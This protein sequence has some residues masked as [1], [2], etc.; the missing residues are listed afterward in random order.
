M[1]TK[2]NDDEQYIWESAAGGTFTIT[3]DTVNPSLGRGTQL[4][5][6]MKEDQLDYLEEKKIKDIVKKHSEFISYPIQL[7]TVKEVEK[8]VEVEEEEEDADKPKIEEVEDEETKKEKKTKKV[9]EMVRAPSPVRALLTRPGHRAGRAQQ[10][11]APLDPQPHRHHRRGVRRFLQVAH[12]RLGGPP[13][14]QA[15]L[16][17]GTARVQGDPLH[18]QAV[19]PPSLLVDPS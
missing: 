18:P 15:L 19:R 3:P 16:R 8:D 13:C 17:R 12:Q 10:D 2:H 11:Q 14:R 4:T 6:H 5:L 1:I 7:V 9:K